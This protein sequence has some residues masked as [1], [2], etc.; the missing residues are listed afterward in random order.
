MPTEKP[1]HFN[2]DAASSDSNSPP[3]GQDNVKCTSEY[4]MCARN[5]AKLVWI[6]KSKKKKKVARIRLLFRSEL[7]LAKLC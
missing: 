4:G 6:N 3:S 5:H 7:V 2:S 1:F